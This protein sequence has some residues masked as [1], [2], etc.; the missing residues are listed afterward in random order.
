MT[1]WQ[2]QNDSVADALWDSIDI[3]PITIAFPK[4]CVAEHGLPEWNTFYWDALMRCDKDPERDS[5]F[6]WASDYKH[7]AHNLV[8]HAVCPPGSQNDFVSRKYF[9]LHGHKP[10]SVGGNDES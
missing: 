9:E 7:M 5:C 10:L 6:Q 2:S 3:S 1:D 8:R 4:L